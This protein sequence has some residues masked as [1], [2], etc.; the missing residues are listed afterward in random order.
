[1]KIQVKDGSIGPKH[2]PYSTSTLIVDHE[3]RRSEFYSDGL[4]SNKL[5]LYEDGKVVRELSWDDYSRSSRRSR[6]ARIQ[7][8]KS[9]L[10]FKRHV[11]ISMDDAFNQYYGS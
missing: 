7:A 4:G 6:W 5:T 8:L 11:G 9:S 10:L 1:M 3:T 2:D